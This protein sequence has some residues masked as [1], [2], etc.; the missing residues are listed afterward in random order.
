MNAATVSFCRSW[1]EAVGMKMIN[2]RGSGQLLRDD[3][4]G[5]LADCCGL[6]PPQAGRAAFLRCSQCLLG[7]SRVADGSSSRTPQQ[8]PMIRFLTPSLFM[9]W[10]LLIAAAYRLLACHAVFCSPLG[11]T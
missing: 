10:L 6:L 3:I 9:D 8:Q 5:R 4:D 2:Q 7:P 11:S 1:A